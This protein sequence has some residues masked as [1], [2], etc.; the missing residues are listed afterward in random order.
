MLRTIT[1][2]FRSRE[3]ADAARERLLAA[4][5]DQERIR[6]VEPASRAGAF[7][8]LTRLLSAPPATDASNWYQLKAEVPASRHAQ[9]LLALRGSAGIATSREQVFEFPEYREELRVRRQAAVKEEVVM[10]REV[11]ETVA[12]VHG[13][14]RRTE[15]E[16][17]EIPPSSEALR[18]GLK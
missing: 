17:E 18:F 8:H 10:R 5:L 9:T 3:E 1:E 6:L 15:V 13:T 2:S 16:V 7:D 14:L 4:G 12:D 11:E